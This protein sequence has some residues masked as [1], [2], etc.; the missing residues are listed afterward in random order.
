MHTS[1]LIS[2]LTV[3]HVLFQSSP[4]CM[5]GC[6][7]QCTCTSMRASKCIYA[8]GYTR[9]RP[10]WS[11][12]PL[13]HASLLVVRHVSYGD[14]TTISTTI[15]STQTIISPVEH[16]S[17]QRPE[18][19]VGETVVES[20]YERCNRH[21]CSVMSAQVHGGAG[22]CCRRHGWRVPWPQRSWEAQA[23]QAFL[24]PRLNEHNAADHWP[25]IL[26]IL[27]FLVVVLFDCLD[28]RQYY[29]PIILFMT[30]ANASF[31]LH[32]LQGYYS[33]G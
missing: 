3:L 15:H 18:N 11:S 5:P 25:A 8:S 26:V 12:R 27:C 13:N 33:H 32:L 1:A 24:E 23:R 20:P 28:D 30:S 9:L 10:A 17:G 4:V 16:P 22:L 31:Q 21:R 14:L 19:I 7:W 2:R 6:M 29:H